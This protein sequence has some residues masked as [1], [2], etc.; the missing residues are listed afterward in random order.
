MGQVVE[1]MPR[2]D[3][4]LSSNPTTTK[5]KKTEKAHKPTSTSPTFTDVFF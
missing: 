2:Q 1:Y 3:H 4:C 5:T